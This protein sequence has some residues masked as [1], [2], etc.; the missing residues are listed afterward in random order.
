MIYLKMAGSVGNHMTKQKNF[1]LF[2]CTCI[3]SLL[4]SNGYSVSILAPLLLKVL[5]NLQF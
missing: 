1:G 3:F 2:K 5:N 4:K